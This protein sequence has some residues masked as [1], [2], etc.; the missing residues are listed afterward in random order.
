MFRG[1]IAL[2]VGVSYPAFA[3]FVTC[4][5]TS[6]YQQTAQDGTMSPISILREETRAFRTKVQDGEITIYTTNGQEYYDGKLGST[7]TAV[8]KTRTDELTATRYREI[9]QITKETV[10]VLLGTNEVYDRESSNFQMIQE[11]ERQPDGSIVMVSNKT[12]DGK[13]IPL[14]DNNFTLIAADGTEYST[15]YDN[16]PKS[17]PTGAVGGGIVTLLYTKRL[18]AIRK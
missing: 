9:S 18:C 7:Y 3:D 10:R 6:A 14:S 16:V 2:L 1:L 5:T 8:R 17:E 4:H 13:D 12:N 15:S 11:F